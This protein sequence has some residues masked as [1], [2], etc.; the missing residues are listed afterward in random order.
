MF[1]ENNV[2]FYAFIESCLWRCCQSGRGFIE[3][4]GKEMLQIDEV[5]NIYL[6]FRQENRLFCG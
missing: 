1:W 6:S 5:G 4:V 3:N 2:S